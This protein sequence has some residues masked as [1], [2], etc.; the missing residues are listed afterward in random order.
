[1]LRKEHLPVQDDIEDP[2]VALDQD[3]SDPDF[4]LDLGRQTGG[5]WKIVSTP[6]IGD[7]NL[8][9]RLR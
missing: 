4:P 3:G 2:V 9:L 1:V 6:A 7:F 5:P 8:H